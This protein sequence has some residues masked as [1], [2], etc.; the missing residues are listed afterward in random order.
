MHQV[1]LDAVGFCTRRPASALKDE[2]CGRAMGEQAS[3]AVGNSPLGGTNSA[4]PA[5]HDTLCLDQTRF[6]RDGPYE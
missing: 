4:A 1:Q 5:Q 3:F 2:A 6:W